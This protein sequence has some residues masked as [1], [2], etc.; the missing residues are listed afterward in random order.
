MLLP[1]RIDDRGSLTGISGLRFFGRLDQSVGHAAH[2]RNHRDAAVL[3]RRLRN[4]FDRARDTGGVAHRRTSEF[5]HLEPRFHLFLTASL[6]GPANCFFWAK[7][8]RFPASC[9]SEFTFGT[10]PPHTTPSCGCSSLQ[11]AILYCS[12]R[13][14]RH[15]LTLFP[16]HT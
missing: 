9:C 16:P 6:Y 15:A 7:L 13:R 10:V 5:H 2:R 4:D 3:F 12:S 11:P 14:A 8:F 1:Q